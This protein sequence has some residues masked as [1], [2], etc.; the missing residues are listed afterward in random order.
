MNKTKK[1]VIVGTSPIG[2]LAYEF[3]THDSEY[4]VAAFTV[5]ESFLTGN[6]FQGLPVTAF[7]TVETVYPP[8]EYEMFVALGSGHLNRDRTRL[9]QQAKAKGYR[10]A[11]YVSSE[12]S[13]W[14]NV[15]IGENCLILPQAMVQPFAKIG[16]NVFLWYGCHIGHHSTVE[17]N[18]FLAISATAGFSA[19][20]KNSFVGVYACVGDNVTVAEDNYLA[21]GAVVGKKTLPNSVYRGNPAQRN[22]IV[23]AKALCGVPEEAE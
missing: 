11:T 10:L 3:F 1:L 20:G 23:S 22:K 15:E 14:H 17:D 19:V 21:M 4:E 6:E 18:C 16:N 7:E 8:A 12:A 2:Q 5:N 13:V 9:Y